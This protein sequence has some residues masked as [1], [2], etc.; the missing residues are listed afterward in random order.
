MLQF[1][2]EDMVGSAQ[3]ER[4]EFSAGAVLHLAW[5]DMVDAALLERIE[6]VRR[7]RDARGYRVPVK[8]WG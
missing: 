7:D 2:G 6:H 3:P 5:E 1:L 4:I 8:G